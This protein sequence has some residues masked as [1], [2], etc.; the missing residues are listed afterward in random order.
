MGGRLAYGDLGGDC[1]DDTALVLVQTA[2]DSGTF[3]YLVAAVRDE[4]GTHGSNGVFLGDRI[5]QPHIT[6]HDGL[7]EVDYQ[8]RAEDYAFSEAPMQTRRAR[9]LTLVELP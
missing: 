4:H 6:L 9:A 7:I 3:S 8:V 2:G 5:E 1:D